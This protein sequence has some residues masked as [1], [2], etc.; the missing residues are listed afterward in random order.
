[1][2]CLPSTHSPLLPCQQVV[3][4]FQS[5]CVSLVELTDGRKGRKGGGDGE[6]D[7]RG[8][9]QIKRR[10]EGLVL[11]KLFNSLWKSWNRYYSSTICMHC[12]DTIPKIWNKYSQKR[13]AATVLIPSFMFMWAIYI[14]LWSVCLFRCRKIGGQNVGIYRSLTDTCGNWDWGRAIPFL[15]IHESKFLC[16]VVF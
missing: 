12:K 2:I 15:G 16:N 11:Y 10:R 5:S 8:K 1:M 4:I 9:N 13:C 7:G 3:S 6:G 14:F